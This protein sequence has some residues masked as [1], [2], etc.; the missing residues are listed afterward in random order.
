MIPEGL[1]YDFHVHVGEKIA[2]HHLRDSF[3][4]L[5]KFPGL[6][7]VGAFVTEEKDQPLSAKLRAMRNAAQKDYSGKVFWHL[8]PTHSSIKD[9]MDILDVDTDIKLYTTYKN[10]G[11]YSSYE[12]IAHY[13]EE[14]SDKKP[15]ILVHCEDNDIIEEYADKYPFKHVYD[16]SLRRPELAENI[17]VEKVLNLALKHSYPIHIVHV[18]S[19]KSALLIKE[20]K[21]HSELITCETAPHYLFWN[22]DKFTEP[23]AHRY[24]CSPPYRSENSRG[25]LV[26]LL[27]DGY[28][29]II[30]TDHCAFTVADKDRHQEEPEKVPC[31]IAGLDH[32][33]DRLYAGLVKPGKI[34]LDYL[35]ELIYT[36]P[37]AMMGFV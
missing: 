2:G 13:M 15:R 14:L 22:V 10:A 16:H 21:G 23:M 1:F 28:F 12:D 8:T 36:K 11:L 31:G 37:A 7:G 17:A 26:E 33:F 24:I 35:S 30:A 4:D 5:V 18:S 29:D 19:P 25:Q 27:Q 9:L 3:A 20:A 32:L 6:L 34:S